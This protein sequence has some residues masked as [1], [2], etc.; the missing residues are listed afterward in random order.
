MTALALSELQTQTSCH[1]ACRR[2][3]PHHA[4]AHLAPAPQQVLDLPFWAHWP[5]LLLFLPYQACLAAL[6][7]TEW[8]GAALDG[9]PARSPRSCG[10]QNEAGSQLG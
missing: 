9:A 8:R 3:P 1:V 5:K 6:V 2:V 4:R 10:V 7:L